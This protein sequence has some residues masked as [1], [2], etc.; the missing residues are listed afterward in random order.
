MSYVHEL[1][2]RY[3]KEILK[4]QLIRLPNVEPIGPVVRLSPTEVSLAD[5]NA[6]KV[7]YKVGG[8]YLKS[9]WYSRFTG[10]MPH[11]NL[12][13]MTNFHEHAQHRRLLAANFAEKWISNLE[14]YM[15][16]IVKL[17]VS[18]MANDFKTDGHCDV[19]K[20]FT[21][22]AT[23]VVGEASFGE[24]F[25]MLETGKKNQYIRDV[26]TFSH[27]GIMRAE[28]P[29]L[30]QL[31]KRFPFGPAKDIAGAVSRTWGYA[32]ESIQRYWKQLQNDPD[33]T[34]PTLL[35]KE[36]AAADE[37]QITAGQIRRDGAGNIVAGTDTTAIAA[38]YAIWLLSLH[39]DVQQDLIREVASLPED[40]SDDQLRSL[41]LLSNVINETLR[42]RG[43]LTQNL[44][45]VVPPGGAEFSGCFVPAGTEVGIHAYTLHR[46]PDVWTNPETFDPSR[47][48]NP[49]KDMLDSLRPFGGGSRG[50]LDPP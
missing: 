47:W 1:H 35:T 50:K 31:M 39:S 24:S 43:P 4:L 21:F 17:A 19:F 40:F 2:Q 36:F 44:P 45:R 49:T 7:V 25:H 11:R 34:K 6:A 22:M 46:S 33:N 12:F 8:P 5:V 48:D 23:D 28:F 26:E 32:E 29:M 9:E 42:Y 37:G 20:W 14:P 30:L 3:G 18:K 13:D 15:S 27:L 10:S 38:T 16:K 41:K